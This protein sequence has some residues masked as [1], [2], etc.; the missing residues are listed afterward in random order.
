MWSQ[1]LRIFS[2]GVASL[3]LSACGGG[4]G[5]SAP[6]GSDNTVAASVAP[7]GVVSVYLNKSQSVSIT[8]A[9]SDGRSASALSASLASL[10]V[11][12]T[13]PAG[14]F[15]CPTVGAGATCG[16]ALQYLPTEPGNGTFVLGFSYRANN[17][18]AKQ[19]AVT[20]DYS[21]LSP[22]LELLAGSLGG[23]G[24]VDGPATEASFFSPCDVAVDGSATAYVVDSMIA[25]VR[26]I[27]ADG[28]VSTL[29]GARDAEGSQDGVGPSVR[30]KSLTSVAVGADG[31]IYAVDSGNHK[32]RSV[33]P[34]GSTSTFAGGAQGTSDGTGEFAQFTS[35]Y[36]IA[37]DA[38]SNLY[39]TDGRRI[40]KVTPQRV[41]TTHP[42][43]AFLVAEVPVELLGSRLGG[44]AV[45]SSGVVY[46]ADRSAIRKVMPDGTVTTFAG[47]VE[48]SG[49]ADG[50]GAEARFGDQ[51]LAA[52]D[53][54]IDSGGNLYVTDWCTIRKITPAAVVTTLAGDAVECGYA[55]GVGTDARF[56]FRM[57]IGIDS[58]GTLYVTDSLNHVIRSVTNEGIVTTLAGKVAER[59]IKDGIG[60]AARFRSPRNIAVDRDGAAFVADEQSIRKVT[61][62]GLV[63]TL[64][65]VIGP[66]PY[67]DPV[68]ALGLA[69]DSGGTLWFTSLHSFYESSYGCYR[70]PCSFA[71]IRTL[72]PDGV[73]TIFGDSSG[74]PYSP[75]MFP[76]PPYA[77][78][79]AVSRDGTLYLWMMDYTIRSISP[80]RVV[81][82][83]AGTAGVRGYADGAGAAAMFG[84]AMYFQPIA[85][86]GHGNLYVADCYNHAVRKVTAAGVVTTLAGD[87]QSEGFADGVGA[88]AKFRCP[89]AIAAHP[90]GTVY[91]TDGATIRKITPDG[92]VTTVVG[93][94]PYFGQK[95]GPLPA[96]LNEPIG[97]AM[98][99]DGQLVIVDG[100][101]ILITRGL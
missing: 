49:H 59:G 77:W 21:G 34:G 43:S 9:T 53:M 63:T 5:G 33:T 80:D 4:D 73:A 94:P 36:R 97:V 25:A 99:E 64:P 3:V 61:R 101:A 56:Q 55:D 81:N 24:N 14:G 92:V 84:S 29:A 26:R 23:G 48:L 68:S 13:G 47:S 46:V 19:G 17:G 11:G 98:T 6:E 7:A 85:L 12:W 22:T 71:L 82:S 41:V 1:F 45:D 87:A 42:A 57:G 30:F 58:R 40:R 75:G 32:I 2:I 35:P 51:G 37:A 72:T 69:V 44:L 89:G 18:V 86:D 78:S 79:I 38:G 15:A 90:G 96:S 67:F 91:V 20:I 60:S 16:L 28:M 27:A 10:P 76:P 31:M 8:F 39:V 62:S 83:L 50:V 93:S 100:A 88:S 74:Q 52:R 65:P 66:P 95:L 54:V 70:P